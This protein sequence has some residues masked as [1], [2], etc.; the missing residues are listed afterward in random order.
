MIN[1][2]N[3][4][5]PILKNHLAGPTGLLSAILARQLNLKVIVID[6][7]EGP[8]KVGGADALTARTQQYLEVASNFPYSDYNAQKPRNGLLSELLNQG[9]RCNSEF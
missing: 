3:F 2:K 6:A 1:P 7:K 5:L 4:F 8:L 9:V